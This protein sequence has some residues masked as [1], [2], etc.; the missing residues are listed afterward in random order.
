MEYINLGKTGLKVSRLSL[1]CMALGTSDWRPWVANEPQAREVIKTALDAGINY[2]DTANQYSQGVSEEVAGRT[3]RDMA[4]RDE[5][6]V[7]TK[8]ALP[9]GDMPTQKGLSRKHIMDSINASLS[10]LGMDYVD[11]Y[12]CHRWDYETPIEETLEALHDVRKAGK[13]RYIGCSNFFTRQLAR[14]LYLADANGW[15]RFVSIQNHFNLLDRADEMEMLPLCLEEGIAY[16]PWSPLARGMLAGADYQGSDR[17]KA[18]GKAANFYG[19]KADAKIIQEVTRIAKERG[20]KAA[21]IATA[22]LL[23][24]KGMTSPVIGPTEAGQLQELIAAIDITL[25]NEEV[26]RLEAPYELKPIL[27]VMKNHPG[28]RT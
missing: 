4:L 13:A 3:L 21:Q 17:A 14:A 10:R 12:V 9:Q 24:V 16:T 11:M 7:S 1:G 18:D 22:W 6:V 8:V 5:I 25:S 20:V 23:Q 26:A 28:N 19:S 2:F 27:G 15:P